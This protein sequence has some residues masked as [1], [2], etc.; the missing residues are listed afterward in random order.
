MSGIK[1]IIY[2][3]AVQG[4]D[5]G[6][7]IVQAIRSANYRNEVDV[8]IICRGGGSMQDLWCFNEEVV[9]REVF[10]SKIPII[11]AIGHETDTTIIDYV[12]DLRAPTPTGAAEIVAKSRDE[13]LYKVHKLQSQLQNR[14]DTMIN[15][16]KQRLDSYY[17]ALRYLNP[18]NQI[19]EKLQMLRII[20]FKLN[21]KINH[22]FNKNK[23]LVSFYENKINFNKVDVLKYQD[24][25]INLEM[26]LNGIFRR[27]LTMKQNTFSSLQKELKHLN[28]ENVLARGY[29]IIHDNANHV[30]SSA[31][32]IKNHQR[33]KIQFRDG[34]LSALADTKHNP[35]QGELI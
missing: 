9:A 8:L 2:H 31:K 4:L 29:A 11:S 13:W 10:A 23:T 17:M 32:T 22:L 18:Q 34:S 26:Q 14:F 15:D 5:A 19:K 7:Q 33:L 21:E 6:M 25:I 16:K 27:N 24:Q 12:A 28:P 35:Q 1:I 30:L 20:K 3:S